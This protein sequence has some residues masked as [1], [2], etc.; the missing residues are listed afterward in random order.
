MTNKNGGRGCQNCPFSCLKIEKKNNDYYQ[1]ET[2]LS[3][4][5]HML[6]RIRDCNSSHMT[7]QDPV[8]KF[9]AENNP[10]IILLCK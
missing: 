9:S 3:P 1:V 2:D 10:F 4:L 5:T 7:I 8:F 6:A